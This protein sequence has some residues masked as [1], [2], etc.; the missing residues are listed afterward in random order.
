MQMEKIPPEK[1]PPE[2][3]TPEKISSAKIL[4]GRV[5]HKRLFPKV[6]SF[7]YRV[8]YLVLPLSA[9]DSL[10]VARNRSAVVS[11]YDRDHGPRN[12]DGL[13][14]WARKLLADHGVRAADGEIILISMPRIF[15]YVFN[16]V[17]FWVCCDR[18]GR[19]RAVLCEVDNTFGEHHIYICAHHNHR[20]IQPGDILQGQK[21][22][23]VSPMLQRQGFYRFRFDTGR[24]DTEGDPLGIWIDFYP[25][26]QGKQLTTSLTGNLVD[27]TPAVLRRAFWRHP[28]LTLKVISAIHWQAV[29]LLL[30]GVKYITKP[31]QKKQTVSTTK[32]F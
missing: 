21:I 29:K 11:F 6:N 24:F 26:D 22:F 30:K 28:L 27:M 20:P 8:F 5:A 25:D 14:D 15:G 9:L 10:P 31:Q 16:P 13:Q 23:H 19:P 17:S 18:A 2:K 12:G 3:I 1:I 7:W 32:N 4:F